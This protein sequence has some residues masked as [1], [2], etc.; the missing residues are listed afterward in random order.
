[1]SLYPLF[2][3]LMFNSGNSIR[4]TIK[5]SN[6]VCLYCICVC[7][8]QDKEGRLIK[9]NGNHFQPLKGAK[10]ILG[11]SKRPLLIWNE[12]FTA[13]QDK[14]DLQSSTFRHRLRF[15]TYIPLQNLPYNSFHM[16]KRCKRWRQERKDGSRDNGVKRLDADR[17]RWSKR[18]PSNH[19]HS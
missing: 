8:R 16:L 9:D 1:M 5:Y 4:Q 15:N 10:T 19:L 17:W 6:H 18:A 13:L 14:G 3:T 7:I 2:G 11:R 12:T